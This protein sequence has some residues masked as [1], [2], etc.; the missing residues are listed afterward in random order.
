MRHIRSISAL[1]AL[2][3]ATMLSPAAAQQKPL[4]QQQQPQAAPAG[5]YKAVAVTPPKP[6][7]DPS[8]DAFRK[9]VGDIARKKDRAALG[10]FVVAQ[11]FFWDR[12]GNPG[13]NKKKSGIDNLATALGLN[14]KD[15]AGWDMLAGYSD[16]PTA[17]ASREH[18]GAMCA[19][20]D[21][22]FNGKDFEA[23][24]AATKTD[25]SEWGFPISADVEVRA[26]PQPNAPVTE[27]L[28]LYFVH[29]MPDTSP[30]A[31]VAAMLHIVMPSGK[32][33]YIAGDA[34]APIG[35]DQVCYVK[36]GGAWKIAG[37]IGG[38]DQ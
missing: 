35:N 24:L 20:A 18:K 10:Q 7:N 38:G 23:L 27:K 13:A 21:P 37:Y 2:S 6:M 29:V 8:F 14:N 34:I 31:A 16:D 1:A 26:T 30:A 17:S 3:I 32:T 15:G 36:E 4:P 11:G 5:P 25:V 22:E 28:G 33:G 19:P 9:Q 12:Q